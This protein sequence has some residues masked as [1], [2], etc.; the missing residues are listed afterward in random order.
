MGAYTVL[1]VKRF[2][3]LGLAFAF[4]LVSC[5]SDDESAQPQTGDVLIGIRASTDP[6]VGD[7][8]LLF[9]VNEINGTRRGSP[10]EMVT[11]VAHSLEAPDI[12]I[13]ADAIFTWIVPG[14]I[15]LY[16]AYVPFDRAGLWEID[17]TIS[18]GEPTEPFL[19]DIQAE[20]QTVAIGEPAPRVKTPTL[21]DRPIEE[22]TTDANPLPVL[23]ESSLDDLLENGQKTVLLFATPAYC[24]SATCGPLVNQ[25][26]E[27]LAV[28]PGVNFIHIE[29]YEGFT[30]V[31]FAPD[32]EHLV[33][34][35]LAFGL[36]S[37]PWIFV[38][39]EAG[40]VIARLDGV[41][42]EGELESILKGE[43]S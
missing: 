38:M 17:F 1:S 23:Y 29:V 41:L 18:T 24:V 31:G 28:T 33:P 9:G 7:D 16:R 4:V 22:L 30:E 39:D 34:A 10:E 32:A 27:V 2:V 14:S 13:E 3:A 21:A 11:I 26:K 42:G 19:I 25:T 20:P 6:A 37:E 43:S 36:P 15:G 8:R 5:A 40:I 35:V 12:K